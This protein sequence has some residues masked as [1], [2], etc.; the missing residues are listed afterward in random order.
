MKRRRRR[1]N[2]PNHFFWIIL[3]SAGCLSIFFL[4]HERR[5]PAPHPA[6]PASVRA[7]LDPMKVA[8]RF[9]QVVAQ[10][11]GDN[12][13]I[14]SAPRPERAREPENSFEV[15][16]S[17]QAYE[18]TLI[19]V[20]REA[21]K[22]GLLPRFIKA[23]L[24]EGF[25]R[26]EI[27]LYSGNVSV[28]HL[29]LREVPW[30]ARIAIVVDDLGQNPKAAQ[31]LL[32]IRAQLT[33][34]VM[35]WLPYSRQTAEA[36]HRAGVEV[37]LHLPMQPL[38]NFA[39]DVSPREI[40][41]GMDGEEVSRMIEKDLATV[42]WVAGVNNHMGSRATE[43]AQL[44]EKVM[45]VLG[46]RHLYF[47]DSRTT[48]DSVALQVARRLSV[49]AFYRSVFLDDVHTVPYTVEQLRKLC[50]IAE[51]QGA[52]LAIGHPYPTTLSALEQFVPE[53]ERENI[54]LVPVSRLLR[55]PEVARLSP[56]PPRLTR[57]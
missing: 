16:A 45:T 42:P 43:D 36:A 41:E 23:A 1:K 21:L 13:W 57:E 35:P 29:Q 5:H 28:C 54:E 14:H 31:E 26:S 30:I 15:L 11:G 50:R 48:P 9:R 49:P 22:E 53:L 3:A 27:A 51:R 55:L 7:P 46:Q 17:P 52:A 33:F 47:V 20:R 10:A 12:V 19:A 2:K 38:A 34:S 6:R 37:M 56:P 25:S 18:P 8:E 24:P 32:R 4:V 39:P 44:M 40:R